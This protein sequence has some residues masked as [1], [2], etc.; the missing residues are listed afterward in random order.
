MIGVN[1]FAIKYSVVVV[2][3]NV[4]RRKLKFIDGSS[5]ELFPDGVTWA[6]LSLSDGEA[7]RN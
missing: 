4:T 2:I 7:Q 3:W 1:R 5:F 6:V